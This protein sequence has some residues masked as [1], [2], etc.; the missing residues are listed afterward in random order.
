MSPI[1]SPDELENIIRNRELSPVF[2][3]IADLDR[4]ELIGFEA[5]IRG[6]ADSALHSPVML[7]ETA[8]RCN[9]LSELEYACIEVICAQFQRLALPGKLFLNISP[10]SLV[11]KKYRQD[12]CSR[13]LRQHD[14]SP[15]R[16]VI[17]LSEAYPLDDYTHI[18]SATQ[19]YRELGFEIAVDDLGAGYAGLRAWAELR[20]NYVKIDRH[21]IE[22]IDGDDVKREFV[23]SIQEIGNNLGCKVVAEG[24]ETQA[25]LHTLQAIG[26]RIG[27]GYLLG[28]PQ[29]VP[30]L[31]LPLSCQTARPS[32]GHN[33]RYQ[34]GE[35]VAALVQHVPALTPHTPAEQVVQ[36]FQQQ[37]SLR[38]IPIVEQDRP[39]GMVAR[40][41][42]MEVFSRSYSR[43]LHGRKPIWHLMNDAPVLVEHTARLDEASR[44]ITR[45]AD[46]ELIQDFIIT[47]EGRYAGIGHTRALL[48]RITEQ[49][50][51]SARHC[52]PL[53]QLPGSVP[54]NEY[55]EQ[56]LAEGAEFAAVYC[57]LNH[58]K[59][60]NDV[61]GY[62]RGDRVIARVA[63]L[64]RD[65]AHPES[66]FVGHI[67]GDDFVLIMQSGDW[68]LRL[69]RLLSQFEASVHV[70]HSNET[71]RLGGFWSQ[72]RRGNREFFPRLSLAIGVALPDSSRCDSYHDVSAMMAA[73]KNMA[74]R[75]PGS[76]LFVCQRRGPS[77]TQPDTE[78]HAAS[79]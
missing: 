78:A 19:D 71:L 66:D 20:P 40:Q 33:R 75:Q 61:Y 53:T 8:D 13:L 63:D 39:V 1:G 52:N 24:I 3:P 47:E 32:A 31:S 6:P 2:Q 30:N 37:P 69:E 62:S 16:I 50:I 77:D 35:T 44:R 11:E 21:F 9:L 23:R 56:L 5:L 58:F 51:L 41:D 15:E 70:F 57:D 22:N 73:A 38:S 25:E 36:Q 27:Q 59:P 74:K 42:L 28:R 12:M 18:R 60:Y 10:I 46:A 43:E 45:D 48:T 76:H 67:G 64:A 49:Q 79:A 7:F 68:R 26:I 14:L 72:D 29:P 34:R 17:E 4:A 55:I 65:V 54:I